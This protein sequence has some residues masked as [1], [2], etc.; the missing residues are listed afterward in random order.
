MAL[1]IL[2]VSEGWYSTG[3]SLWQF[4]SAYKNKKTTSERERSHMPSQPLCPCQALRQGGGGAESETGCLSH[5]TAVGTVSPR[6]ITRPTYQPCLAAKEIHLDKAASN[7]N[8][9]PL[10]CQAAQRRASIAS[11]GLPFS[12]CS[13]AG[14][15][16]LTRQSHRPAESAVKRAIVPG[17]TLCCWLNGISP[18]FSKSLSFRPPG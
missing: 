16:P 18:Y 7:P 14:L 10:K 4:P 13:F 11:A 9:K 15:S 2:G 12:F 8:N 5:V 3:Y 17:H 6:A 1:V